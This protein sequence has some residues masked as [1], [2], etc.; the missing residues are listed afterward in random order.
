VESVVNLTDELLVIDVTR[1]NNDKIV[2]EVIGGLISS[3]IIS[4]QVAEIICITPDWLSHHV[5]SKCIEVRILESSLLI[6]F[7][8][9]A[10]LSSDVLFE[11]FKLTS[12]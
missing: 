5:V 10:V 11:K 4:S 12:I 6:M 8:A 7:V 9:V 1:S 2:T 3:E